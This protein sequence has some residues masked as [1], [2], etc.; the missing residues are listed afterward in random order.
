MLF[1]CGASLPAGDFESVA[2]S[3]SA[4]R[5][6]HSQSL[7]S[8]WP[9]PFCIPA[10]WPV[11]SHFCRPPSW[12]DAPWDWPREPNAL[13]GTR[14]WRPRCKGQAESLAL[15]LEHMQ[16]KLR[17]TTASCA[18]ADVTCFWCHSSNATPRHDIVCCTSLARE[19]LVKGASDK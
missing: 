17:D 14:G 19:T 15:Y 1:H 3:P 9:V 8:R 12:L 16:H 6:A 11:P 2:K 10:L 18:I 13:C 5:F 7:G 4:S